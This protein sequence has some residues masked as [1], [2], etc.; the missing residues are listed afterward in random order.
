[1]TYWRTF[2]R[3]NEDLVFP[4]GLSLN[5]LLLIVIKLVKVKSMQKYN[6]LL[7]QCCCIDLIQNIVSFVVKPVVIMDKKNIYL[8]SNGFLR[9]IGGLVEVI[10]FNLWQISV[11]LCM[12]SIPIS[13]VFR[14]RTLCFNE[15]VSSKLYITSLIIAT[16]NS[17]IFGVIV[18]KFHYLDNWNKT[19]LADENI[20]WL[21]AD[22]EGK[23]KALSV[24][25]AVSCLTI[26]IQTMKVI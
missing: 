22:D 4:L 11:F 19:Y 14:Y 18:F 2:H 25:F 10:G 21:I 12:C 8:L 20:G 9:P 26:Q 13:Y 23:V 16:L 7:F 1:M 5:I 3:I 17:S 15:E 6:R 24:C